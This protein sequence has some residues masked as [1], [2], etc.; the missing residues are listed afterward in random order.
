MFWYFH[1]SL[2]SGGKNIAFNHFCRNGL[3][4]PA[5]PQSVTAE[6]SDRPHREPKTL[7][8]IL[9]CLLVFGVV[10]ICQERCLSVSKWHLYMSELIGGCLEISEGSVH[11]GWSWAGAVRQFGKIFWFFPP[12]FNETWKSLTL[13]IFLIFSVC[14]RYIKSHS[15]S[16]SPCKTSQE[17]RMLSS[18]TINCQITKIVMNS[19]SQLSEL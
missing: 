12:D 5:Y 14:Q 7:K 8:Y 10:L 6:I 2:K 1:V 3:V 18:V 9:G 17:L 13:I 19:G 16:W 4:A 15:L 11:A